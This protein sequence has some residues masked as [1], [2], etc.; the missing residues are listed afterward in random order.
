MCIL[1]SLST[2]HLILTILQ[3]CTFLHRQKYSEAAYMQHD[4]LTNHCSTSTMQVE[5]LRP[6]VDVNAPAA[7]AAHH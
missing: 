6:D 3:L 7:A 4:Q 5:D 2:P 1:H